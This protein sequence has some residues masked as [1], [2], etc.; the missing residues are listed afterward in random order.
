MSFS[1]AT[2]RGTYQSI[3]AGTAQAR[4]WTKSY[5]PLAPQLVE[6]RAVDQ[7]LR[8]LFFVRDKQFDTRAGAGKLINGSFKHVSGARAGQ[9]LALM[10]EIRKRTLLVARIRRQKAVN[11][12]VI[13]ASVA[14]GLGDPRDR[15]VSPDA[16]AYFQ[17]AK[18]K[19]TVA[20]PNYWQHK[21][22]SY[23]IPKQNWRRHPELG[24]IT[25]VHNA[26]PVPN[27]HH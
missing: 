16:A 9:H 15:L 18:H 2:G 5:F 10:A 14:A 19:Y 11:N 8:K 25:R 21:T 4:K 6:L 24:G 17:P 12:E 7:N 13:A 23:V 22:N 1:G 26:M 27:S 3:I 20:Q